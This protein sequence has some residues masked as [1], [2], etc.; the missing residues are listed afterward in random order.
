MLSLDI[1]TYPFVPSMIDYQGQY[2]GMDT[3]GSNILAMSVKDFHDYPIQD[4]D[5]QYN[6]WGF[7]GEDFEQYIGEKVNICLGDSMAVNIGGPVE[8]GFCSQ[9]AEHFD[10]PTLNF[11]MAAAGN[12]AIFKVYESAIR[13]FDV[14]N[15]FVMYSFL[16]RRLVDGKF[17]QHTYTDYKEDFSYF[18]KQR[19]PNAIE[20]ALPCWCWSDEEKQF[21]SNQGIYFLDVPWVLYFSDYQTMDRRFIVKESY[22]NLRGPDWPTLKEFING[23]EP[24]PDMFTKQFGGFMPRFYQQYTNRDGLHLNY[25]AN[26]I[27]ADYLYQQWS[28]HES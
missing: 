15:T 13:F 4:F 20:C 10:I 14:Q 23:A 26:K 22:N 27:Y 24:H 18:N 11:G 9:L 8:H 19:I 6:S 12:D 28:K 17:E 3:P 2:S 16:H 7:R 1:K 5:Y 21:L 25:N